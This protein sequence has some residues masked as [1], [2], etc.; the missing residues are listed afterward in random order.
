ME[1]T[2]CHTCQGINAD[3]FSEKYQGY[4]NHFDGEQMMHGSYGQLLASAN[5]GC[6]SCRILVG[7]D[8]D[9]ELNDWEVDVNDRQPIYLRR[10]E[11]FPDR[12]VSVCLAHEEKNWIY[13]SLTPEEWSE[14]LYA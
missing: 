3:F 14:F 12:M 8:G 9:G 2:I 11:E 6:P 13:F 10:C 5:N 7:L 1:G 4:P